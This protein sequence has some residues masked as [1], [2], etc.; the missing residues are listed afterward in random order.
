MSYIYRYIRAN[1][2]IASDAMY[3]V[4]ITS[5]VLINYLL[6]LYLLYIN[7]V[8]KHHPTSFK[9]SLLGAAIDNKLNILRKTAQK[10]PQD[11][12]KRKK[13]YSKHI[14]QFFK[15]QNVL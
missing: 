9:E 4:D 2:R 1:V 8:E 12:Q 6:F 10:M 14:S 13:T 7:A 15:V 3:I 5:C 11:L